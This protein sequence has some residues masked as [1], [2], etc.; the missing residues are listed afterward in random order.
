MET[1]LKKFIPFG[2]GAM[3]WQHT[4]NKLEPRAVRGT[5]LGREPLRHTPSEANI[6]VGKNDTVIEQNM[7]FRC[8]PGTLYQLPFG[9]NTSYL[10]NLIAKQNNFDISDIPGSRAKRRDYTY[11]ERLN[12]SIWPKQPKCLIT[13]PLENDDMNSYIHVKQIY[14]IP[15]A[16]SGNSFHVQTS[17]YLS[18]GGNNTTKMSVVTNVVWAGQSLLRDAIE[19]DS[20]GGQTGTTEILIGEVNK[21][22]S[23]TRITGKKGREGGRGISTSGEGG[24]APKG[25]YIC[26]KHAYKQ[27]ATITRHHR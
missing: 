1:F 27:N 25:I 13:E 5:L 9:G 2:I 6:V 11:T 24:G 12:N 23:S 4:D 18:W 7:V 21:I 10:K 19:R 8:T 15:G 14:K 20:V 17:F 3:V 22:L 26:C 16:P